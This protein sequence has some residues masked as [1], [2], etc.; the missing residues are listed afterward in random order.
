MRPRP[1]TKPPPVALVG[2][3]DHP[4]LRQALAT[5]L[6]RKRASVERALGRPADAVH[7]SPRPS[8]YRARLALR[9]DADGWLGQSLPG[10]H[11][12]VILD[13]APLARPE[14]SALLPRLPAF[15][16]LGQVELRS[17]GAGVVLSAW[18]PRK[19]RGARDRRNQGL[20]AQARKRL[21]DLDLEGI[22]LLGVALDGQ[23]LAGAVRTELEVEGVAHSLSP[24]SFYQVNLEINALLVAAVGR[25]VRECGPTALLDLYSG[26]GNL[27][28]PLVKGG[29][30]AVLV[31][32]GASS[33]ADARRC[34]ARMGAQAEV[35]TA[36]A[37][38]FQPGD[39]FFDVVILDPPREGAPGLL[40]RLLVTRPSAVIYV[41]CNPQAL[42]R[43]LR[44]SSDLGY[45]LDRVEIFDMFPQTPHVETLVRL[46]RRG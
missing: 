17:D 32:Q 30:A 35:R 39:A 22:G 21:L 24:G 10:T 20:G 15:P 42:A 14:I 37:G 46:R 33:A 5:E 16:G 29:L 8:A 11:D 31:E 27:S 43:D 12:H 45:T 25:M 44:G 4:A 41:S 13:D 2:E 18:S 28:L 38:K 7:P 36:D 6:D 9:P 1:P 26:A 3:A 19:G 34:L 40:P 23:A